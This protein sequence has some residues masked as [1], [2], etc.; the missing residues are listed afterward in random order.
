MLQRV[1]DTPE[2]PVPQRYTPF[3]KSGNW[4]FAISDWVG[5]TTSF[6]APPTSAYRIP[7]N[8]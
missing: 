7:Y 3:S 5:I 8:L 6:S 1:S 4:E 2:F